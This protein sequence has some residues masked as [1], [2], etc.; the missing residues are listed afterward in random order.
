MTIEEIWHLRELLAEAEKHIAEMQPDY[1]LGRLVRRMPELGV[2][3]LAH[4]GG[5]VIKMIWRYVPQDASRPYL[6]GAT[7]EI[8]LYAALGKKQDDETE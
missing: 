4:C 6:H 7:P 5:K 3:R 2:C 1:E 8:V